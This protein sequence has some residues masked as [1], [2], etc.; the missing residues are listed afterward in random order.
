MAQKVFARAKRRQGVI[1]NRIIN[2]AK[3]KNKLQRKEAL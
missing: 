2:N 1:F 3:S